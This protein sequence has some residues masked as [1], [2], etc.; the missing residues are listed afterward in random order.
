MEAWAHLL[1]NWTYLPAQGDRDRDCPVIHKVI[2]REQ[3][4]R[5]HFDVTDRRMPIQRDRD[6]IQP[7]NV[8][9]R[10][11]LAESLRDTEGVLRD[12]LL[13]GRAL[14]IMVFVTSSIVRALTVVC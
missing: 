14:W 10:P 4:W 12:E 13:Q 9:R 8:P 2:D 1:S 5:F 7:P 11:K 3:L 6:E